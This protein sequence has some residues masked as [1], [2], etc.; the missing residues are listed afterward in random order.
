MR[1]FNKIFRN[2]AFVGA[3][4]VG[5]ALGGYG[6]YRTSAKPA[7]SVRYMTA[8]ATKHSLAVS[9]S[10]SGQMSSSDR[11]D[12]KPRSA[13]TIVSLAAKQ[14]QTVSAGAL[15]AAIDS[16][17]A[18]RAV[19]DAETALETARLNLERALEDTDPLTALQQENTLID[20]GNSLKRA[21][22]NLIKAYSDGY[23]AVSSAFLDLPDL[24][25][26]LRD[27]LMGN[28]INPNQWNIDYYADTAKIYDDRALS[29]RDDAYDAYM[30]ARASYDTAFADFKGTDRGTDP[31]TVVSIIE[32][33]YGTALAIAAAVKDA[34]DLVQFYKDQLT[35]HGLR[36]LA[37]ADADLAGLNGF[38]GTINGRVT[39]LLS[40]KQAI[41]NAK[42]AI[43]AAKRNMAEKQASVDKANAG[44]DK[45]DV[46]A[47]RI[48][49]EQKETA[50]EDAKS[51]L[52][53]CYVRAPFSGILASVDAKKGDYAS[54][55]TA[56]ATII[57]PKQ[58]AEITLN[59][60]DVAKVKAGHKATL[61][62][63]AVEGL[64]VTGT[65]AQ[66]DQL[67]TVSQGVV[68]YDI[69]IS[70]DTQDDRI[71]PGMSVNASIVTDFKPDVL[72]VP[73]AA[74]K[75][76]N[77]APYVQ[78]M[79]EGVPERR[80]V[81]VGIANDTETEITGGLEEGDE[82]VTQTISSSA[83]PS[84]GAR[85]GGTSGIPGLGGGVRIQTGGSLMGR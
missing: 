43:A 22:D 18:V 12:V 7:D 29:Y 80:A 17:D 55:G 62:F 1:I 30:E 28:G 9:V 65:V 67:G 14:G 25:T 32:E 82:V 44:P 49:I 24:V 2:K 75:F 64:V 37:A 54:T 38:T 11:M 3:L 21:E 52:A 69:G 58:I 66:I 36:P 53:D 13:G 51:R 31:Q 15:L 56:I 5:A 10:G 8:A 83:S 26:G 60:T 27:T 23:T 81:T 34:N 6:I 77:G 20:A 76:Q 57:S 19:K 74:V 47:L 4:A 59:E 68:S 63:D 33:A 16:R 35:V 45:L 70:L 61:T 39:S 72:T 84:A 41:E 73:S 85:T 71:L 40:A 46:R 78:T 50:L 42:D 79:A 48:S